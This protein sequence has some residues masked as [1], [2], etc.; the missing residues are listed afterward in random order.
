M[1]ECPE[2]IIIF[3]MMKLELGHN[4]RE[5]PVGTFVCKY[6]FSVGITRAC[7]IVINICY[8]CRGGMSLLLTI[9]K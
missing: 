5:E 7:R 8:N 9:D 4:N 6:P 3:I 1:L 2:I